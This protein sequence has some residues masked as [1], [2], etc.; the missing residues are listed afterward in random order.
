V[1]FDC[2]NSQAHHS[3]EVSSR[4]SLA[5]GQSEC[6][7]FM[8]I[9]TESPWLGTIGEPYNTVQ[10]K[11]RV[12]LVKL[13]V[14]CMVGATQDASSTTLKSRRPLYLGTKIPLE[15]NHPGTPG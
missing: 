8:E 11:Q 15:Q 6:T 4:A 9:P 10:L 12:K 3:A 1:W 5:R 14:F 7:F 13:T 2:G